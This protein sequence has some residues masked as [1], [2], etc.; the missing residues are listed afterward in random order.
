MS[1]PLKATRECNLTRCLLRV[2]HSVCLCLDHETGDVE[3][4]DWAD[5]PCN[6]CHLHLGSMQLPPCPCAMPMCHLQKSGDM[7]SEPTC[8]MF[9]CVERDRGVVG[10][11]CVCQGSGTEGLA[12]LMS[13]T[14]HR[15]VLVILDTF[16]CT[17]RKRMLSDARCFFF[18]ALLVDKHVCVC[19]HVC[20][21]VHVT[22]HSF[23]AQPSRFL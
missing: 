7:C 19:L 20:A 12:A 10:L 17:L 13:S 16:V 4:A 15:N 18:L 3:M 22:L 23:P 14:I 6:C 9:L 8:A 2:W 1:W 21:C 11:G 5:T